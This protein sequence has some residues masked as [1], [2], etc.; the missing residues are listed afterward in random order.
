MKRLFILMAS[1]CIVLNWTDRPALAQHSHGGQGMG[2]REGMGM[3]RE[4]NGSGRS[5][6]VAGQKMGRDQDDAHGKMAI[7]DRL[8]RTPQLSSRLQGLLPPGTNLQDASKEFKN[9]G[10][11][12]AAVHVSHNLNIPY[13]QLKTK[14]TGPSAVSLGKAIQELQPNANAK[15]ELKKAEKEAAQ[16]LREAKEK[17]EAEP[18]EAA[19][20]R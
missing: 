19:E 17:Q 13:D 8:A 9:L 3:G 5:G 6:S 7:G 14:M 4:T 10:Q 15:A 1:L 16:D 2:N 12:V 18:H 20:K 11:F